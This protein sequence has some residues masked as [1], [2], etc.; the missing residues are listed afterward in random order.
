MFGAPNV[1]AKCEDRQVDS[2][3]RE[4]ASSGDISTISI[5]I[6]SA[7]KKAKREITY[8]TP[9]KPAKYTTTDFMKDMNEIVEIDVAETVVFQTTWRELI[10]EIVSGAC[11]AAEHAATHIAEI[12]RKKLLESLLEPAGAGKRVYFQSGMIMWT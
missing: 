4:R 6:K 3:K 12:E 10:S 8:S 1:L 2:L 11:L 5:D 7:P 9:H